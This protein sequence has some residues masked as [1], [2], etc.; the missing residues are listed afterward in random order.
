[1]LNTFPDLLTYSFF[2]PTILRLFAAGIFAYGAYYA[3]QHRARI[4]HLRFPIIGQAS[5]VGGAS[6]VVHAAIAGMLGTG[7][8]TQVAAIL[9]ALG[10]IKGYVYAK[11]YPELFPFGRSTYVLLLA[12]LLSLL[13]TGAGALAF[14]LPL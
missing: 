13:L 1:M 14:D 4:A 6:A 8:Y 9:G 12:I 5:W 3:W 11:R 7:Y 2:A 10:A